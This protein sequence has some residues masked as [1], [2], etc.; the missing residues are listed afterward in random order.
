M[1]SETKKFI[2]LVEINANHSLGRMETREHQSSTKILA[3]K[4]LVEELHGFR[5]KR[6]EKKKGLGKRGL[7]G[8][9]EAWEGKRNRWGR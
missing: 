4:I 3:A 5:L 2:E 6:S 8:E 9:S 7:G 1:G